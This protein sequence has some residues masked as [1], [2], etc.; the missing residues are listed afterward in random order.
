[1]LDGYPITA[2]TD[3]LVC[4]FVYLHIK[5][6]VT[7]NIADLQNILGPENSDQREAT[8][9]TGYTA[10]VVGEVAVMSTTQAFAPT[11]IEGRRPKQ[12]LCGIAPE[13]QIQYTEKRFPCIHPSRLI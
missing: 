4:V 9:S 5:Y 10:H 6:S 1:M 3:M 12:K 11:R 7:H 2:G 13:Q 8:N